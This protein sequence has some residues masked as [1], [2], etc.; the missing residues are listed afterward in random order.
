MVA[1]EAIEPGELVLEEP[2]YLMAEC[3][4]EMLAEL[5]DIC[6]DPV[7][8]DMHPVGTGVER[9]PDVITHNWHAADPEIVD[10][11][12]GAGVRR[13][14][15]DLGTSRPVRR[16]PGG[17]ILGLW[18]KGSLINHNFSRPNL[19]RSFLV[20]EEC[21]LAGGWQE[22][23]Y[24]QYRCIRAVHAG[25]EMLDNYMALTSTF[26]GRVEV[27]HAQ[28][29][30]I[31]RRDEFDHP[32]TPE[33]LQRAEAGRAAA[34]PL[35]VLRLLVPMCQ[36][37]GGERE[38]VRDPALWP[39]IFGLG[40]A[41]QALRLWPQALDVY[42]HALRLVRLREPFSVCTCRTLAVLCGCSCARLKAIAAEVDR[43]PE[44]P[45]VGGEVVEAEAA[46]RGDA[47]PG[48]AAALAD[49]R[50]AGKQGEPSRACP[51]ERTE[52][53]IRAHPAY[54]A[55]SS[56]LAESLALA[57]THFT[58]VF[59]HGAFASQNPTLSRI[60]FEAGAALC[61]GSV[62]RF[63]QEEMAGER[64][65]RE[66][67]AIVGKAPLLQQ[68]LPGVDGAPHGPSGGG[69]QAEPACWGWVSRWPKVKDA[70]PQGAGGTLADL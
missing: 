8:Q 34:R 21:A 38:E 68:G 31:C 39:L 33:W 62:L 53:L 35:D 54:R 69:A 20:K 24:V 51:E 41:L 60:G 28:H 46:A 55:A 9:L 5:Q 27:E 70:S 59:G 6:D 3:Y 17:S 12:V 67:C 26:C 36:E 45:Q 57:R 65:D 30:M 19:A 14:R 16:L 23:L 29:N 47:P 37:F 48:Q 58:I 15:W 1:R 52:A 66:A 61:D 32:R 50:G 7:I 4:G 11:E 43:Q 44:G 64:V 63:G 40:R 49:A 18:P 2:A 25:E 13:D 56:E 10:G 22:V 42:A